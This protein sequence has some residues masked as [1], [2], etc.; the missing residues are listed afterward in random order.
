[1]ALGGNSTSIASLQPKMRRAAQLLLQAAPALGASTVRVTSA[2]RSRAQQTQLYKNFLAGKAAFPAAP[3]GQ[4][5]HE[6]GLAVDIVVTPAAAQIALGQWWRKVG[7]IWGG[8]FQ[9]PIHFEL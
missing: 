7:G 1:M 2:K 8:S 4:S 6:Q 3:P 9:D 5:K